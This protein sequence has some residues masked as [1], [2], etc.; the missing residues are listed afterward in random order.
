[1]ARI[2][3]DTWVTFIDTENPNNP[4]IPTWKPYDLRDRAVMHFDIPPHVENDPRGEMRKLLTAAFQI[5]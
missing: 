4:S 3:S 1:M 2:M 5:L